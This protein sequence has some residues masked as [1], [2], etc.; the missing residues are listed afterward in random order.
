MRPRT[1]RSRSLLVI[2][3][4]LALL[5]LATPA[6]AGIVIPMDDDDL[7]RGADVI[8]LGRIARIESH[9][10]QLGPIHTYITVSL[11][12][13]LKGDL[14][15][16]EVTIREIGGTVGDRSYWAFANPEFV[17][18]E[19]VLLFMDQ[20]ADG[21]LRTYHFYLGKFTVVTDRA[22]GSRKPSGPDLFFRSHR[23]PCLPRGRARCGESFASSGIRTLPARSIPP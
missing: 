22:T 11:E 23:R 19:A 13:I 9:R 10:D 3:L 14:R 21:T 17:V 20:R 4:L 16:R 8:V 7:I 1:R 5:P 2:V 6:A 18:G 15:G 12:E